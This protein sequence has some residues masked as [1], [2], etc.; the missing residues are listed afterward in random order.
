[1]NIYIL[2]LHSHHIPGKA[3][4]IMGW[5]SGR[6]GGIAFFSASG[7]RLFGLGLGL[8]F[9]APFTWMGGWMDEDGKGMGRGGGMETDGRT[10]GRIWS[11]RLVVPTDGG[12]RT[13][14]RLY[15]LYPISILSISWAF[16][17]L[18]LLRRCLCCSL[19]ECRSL[20]MRRLASAGFVCLVSRLTRLGG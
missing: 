10:E 17:L 11:T 18:L 20:P 16:L 4:Q 3:G 2:I 15:H 9:F 13:G 1:M 7:F 12:R 6:V 8:G 14:R 5:R 19:Y